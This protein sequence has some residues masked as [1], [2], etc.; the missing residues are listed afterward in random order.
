MCWQS[1]VREQLGR[2]KGF[3]L[4]RQTEPAND[5]HHTAAD[6]PPPC[7]LGTRFA[8]RFSFM[9]LLVC[10]SSWS[11]CCCSCCCT[12]PSRINHHLLKLGLPP[13][14]AQAAVNPGFLDPYDVINDV[15]LDNPKYRLGPVSL[16]SGKLDWV[17][18]RGCRLVHK[19]MGNDNYAAS[20]HKWLMSDIVLL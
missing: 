4:D 15:T 2:G 11:S 7:V 10:C 6:Q 14:V 9:L 5:K 3:R 17:L 12:D 16:M 19:A 1:Q 18:L 8:A 20:D 13:A